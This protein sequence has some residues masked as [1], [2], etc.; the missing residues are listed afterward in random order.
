MSGCVDHFAWD[1]KEAYTCVRNII[2]TLNFEVLE[3]DEEDEE[4][5]R[6][7]KTEEGPLYCSE[8]LLG[9]APQ[10]Y[11]YSVDVKMVRYVKTHIQSYLLGRNTVN[12]NSQGKGCHVQTVRHD[13]YKV[14]HK[15]SQHMSG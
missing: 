5:M 4:K 1:E 15:K 3:E 6:K 14:K 9:L 8:E 11:D 2:S 7:R 12:S 10:S 13:I